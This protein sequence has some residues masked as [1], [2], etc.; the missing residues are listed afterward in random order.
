[1]PKR[2]TLSARKYK[3]LALESL[4]NSLR[5]LKDAISLYRISSYPTA[6]QLA[7]LSMEEYAKAKWVDHVYYSSIT[8]TGLPCEENEQSWLRLLYFH[9]EKQ[10]AFLGSE[11]F[12]FS[13]SLLRAVTTGHLER[14]KQAATYVGLPKKGKTIDVN[15]RVS[16]PSSVTQAD[17]KQ[18]ISVVAREIKDV[19]KLI[20][21][22]DQYFGIE[23][24]DEVL[25][26]HE[27]MFVFAWRHT[28]GLKSGRYRPLH[29]L[30]KLPRSK[31]V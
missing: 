14:K 23:S 9:P 24:L 27:A 30:A 11:Y 10:E 13:P 1:M 29:G 2:T 21:R 16:L 19:Y 31:S 5:L 3:Q 12:E 8:N 26:S 18:M 20:E 25:T 7:V 4:R 17:A 6:F 15:A 22:N 28:S